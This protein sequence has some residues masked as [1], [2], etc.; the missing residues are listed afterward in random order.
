MLHVKEKEIILGV[1]DNTDFE[2][3]PVVNDLITVVLP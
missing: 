2:D 1:S 3:T